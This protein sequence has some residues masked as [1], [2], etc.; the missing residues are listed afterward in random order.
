MQSAP[1]TKQ[2]KNTNSYNKNLP[3]SVED[4]KMDDSLLKY[5]SNILNISLAF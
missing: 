4:M 5:L 1:K 2:N 3:V